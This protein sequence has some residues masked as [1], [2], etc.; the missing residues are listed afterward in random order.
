[1]TPKNGGKRAFWRSGPMLGSRRRQK[2]PTIADSRSTDFCLVMWSSDSARL[3]CSDTTS[4]LTPFGQVHAECRRQRELVRKWE[5]RTNHPKAN[6]DLPTARVW[7][8]HHPQLSPCG[9]P[10]TPKLRGLRGRNW[11]PD[12]G[13]E[14]TNKRL[15]GAVNQGD[16]RN[17]SRFM[18]G[19]HR[20]R[21]GKV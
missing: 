19:G 7:R 3:C 10:T 16:G 17:S 18:C 5:M 12:E 1:M 6:H 21:R 2:S 9:F 4:K 8:L 14:D 13:F 15:S 20:K 11:R